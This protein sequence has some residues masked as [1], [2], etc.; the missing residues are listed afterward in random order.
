MN[1][2]K[3]EKIQK[4]LD[5]LNEKEQREVFNVFESLLKKIAIHSNRK[6]VKR[7]TLLKMAIQIYKSGN[8]GCQ[9]YAR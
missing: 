7:S 4:F 5:S 8:K 9:I 6:K 3:M 2:S 1:Y